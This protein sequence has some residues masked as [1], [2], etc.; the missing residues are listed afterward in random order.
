MSDLQTFLQA[1][2]LHEGSDEEALKAAKKEYWKRYR[3]EHQRRRRQGLRR[4]EVEYTIA[5]G[6]R[7]EEIAHR[8]GH[9][10][11]SH[12]VRAC[13]NAAVENAPLMVLPDEM[14]I[15]ALDAAFIQPTNNLNQIARMANRTVGAAPEELLAAIDEVSRMRAAVAAFCEPVDLKAEIRRHLARDPRVLGEL[16][17]LLDQY[18]TV[19]SSAPRHD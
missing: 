19:P 18:R 13:V 17:Q 12:F 15:N 5:E 6:H 14:R 1:R 8:N 3:Q 16:Q 2:G 4:V 10:N 9:G 11:L 7:L